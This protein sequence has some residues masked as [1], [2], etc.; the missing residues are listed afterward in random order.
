[1][2]D[3]FKYMLATIVGLIV[4]SILLSLISALVIGIMIGIASGD[5]ETDV[6]PN[7]ILQVKLDYM[8][9]DRTPKSPFE[10]FKFQD[11]DFEKRLGLNDILLNIEKAKEDENIKGIYLDLSIVPSGLATLDEVRDALLDFKKSGKFIISYSNSYTQPAYYLATVSDSIYMNPEGELTHKGLAAEVMFF[12]NTLE[13][14]GVDAQIIRHGKFKSAVEPLMLEQMSDENR[15]QYTVFLESMW[16]HIVKGVSQQRNI[17]DTELNLYADSLLIR[18]ADKALQYKLID[19]TK[20]FDQINAQL[21]GLTEVADDKDLKFVS[22]SKYK[23]AP[24]PASGEKEAKGLSREKIAVIYASGSITTGEGDDGTIGSKRISKAIRKA[25]KD[26]RV[27]AIVLRVNSPGGSS[28]PSEIIWREVSLAK[29]QKPVI[30]SFGNLAASGGYYIACAADTI[31]SG[32]TTI[33]G[34]I[35]VFGVLLNAKEMF[36]DKLGITFDRV[37]TNT[38]SDLGTITRE[39]KPKERQVIKHLVE[40]VYDTFVSHVAEGRGLTK[41]EVDSIGQGRVWSGTNAKEIALVDELG[42][43]QRAIEI[44]AEKAGL[45]DYR[46]EELPRQKDPFEQMMSEFQTGIQKRVTRNLLGKNYRY[47]QFIEKAEQLHG[48]QMRLPFD[49]MIY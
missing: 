16:K 43:L 1:M 27:K 13:K 4:A 49:I 34:S 12:K 3:F 25:R 17:S 33:T 2:K 19:G 18:D 11:F 24:A 23:N 30:A 6:K 45:D 29:K 42:G 5:E 48:V 21:K 22:M 15:E 47:Y 35:G 39:L 10:N 20:Y 44:A 41:A 46:I 9:P 14:L 40:N 28:L 32:E 26:D 31:V 37:K 36:N 38:Y 8:I 7:S